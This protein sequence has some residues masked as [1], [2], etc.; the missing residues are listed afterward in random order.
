MG[1]VAR[2]CPSYICAEC[3]QS[4]R[5]MK[6][7]Q[8]EAR[9]DRFRNSNAVTRTQRRF[10]WRLLRPLPRAFICSSRDRE[11]GTGEDHS[12]EW[13]NSPYQRDKAYRSPRCRK[14]TATPKCSACGSDG[15]TCPWTLD[16]AHSMTP[17]M[18][19]L[20]PHTAR[21]G[22]HCNDEA[23]RRHTAR[24]NVHGSVYK[25]FRQILH[26]SPPMEGTLARSAG[27]LL[28]LSTAVGGLLAPADNTD[29]DTATCGGDCAP[30]RA[31][32]VPLAD[33]DTGVPCCNGGAC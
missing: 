19:G 6:G 4:N 25:P 7:V 18:M 2:Q 29:G 11:S 16:T 30:G 14:W 32:G 33:G 9:G 28:S 3:T 22:T 8:G 23:M 26:S 24:T 12:A 10:Q 20:Q 13:K 5:D 31:T 27:G 21:I 17:R 1:V 15:R